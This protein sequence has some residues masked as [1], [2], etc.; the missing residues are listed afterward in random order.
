MI[1]VFWLSDISGLKTKHILEI[2]ALTEMLLF[3]AIIV[4]FS[5]AQQV[6]TLSFKNKNKKKRISQCLSELSIML[7]F[8]KK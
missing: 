6:N 2:I 4:L 7:M 8:S 5:N 3:G 1:I